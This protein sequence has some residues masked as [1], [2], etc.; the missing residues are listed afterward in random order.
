MF[1]QW[2]VDRACKAG[3]A[4]TSKRCVALACAGP[5][6]LCL[7]PGIEVDIPSVDSKIIRLLERYVQ[8]IIGYLVITSTLVQVERFTFM[9]VYN[10]SFTL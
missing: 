2:P 5:W 8:L 4:V 6:I 1:R 9:V 10:C 3:A 7:A